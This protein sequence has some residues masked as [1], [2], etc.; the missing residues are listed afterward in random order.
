MIRQIRD[1][2]ERTGIM[3]GYKP[4]GGIKTAKDSV[5]YLTLI[6]EELGR[7]WLEPEMFRFGASSLL[8]DLERQLEYHATG[9]YSASYR[10]PMG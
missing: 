3:V 7:A 2:Y 1:F 9:G 4:A 5:V 10:H 6:N 8:G